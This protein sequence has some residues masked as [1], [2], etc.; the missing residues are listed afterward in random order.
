MMMPSFSVDSNLT[1]VIR[2]EERRAQIGRERGA[3]ECPHMSIKADP[4]ALRGVPSA[5]EVLDKP[6]P[7]GQSVCPHG[8]VVL[9]E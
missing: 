5:K 9:G 4:V 1:S 3:K 2:Q 6:V 7:L 8:Q